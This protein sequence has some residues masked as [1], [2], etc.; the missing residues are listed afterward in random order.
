MIKNYFIIAL[1]N[2]KKYKLFSFLNISGLALGIACVVL[3]YTYISYELS[4]EKC[5]PKYKRI[6][7]AVSDARYDDGSRK[8]AP[9][10]P[11]LGPELKKSLPEVEEICRF[12]V[13]GLTQCSVSKEGVIS[14]K[15]MES[16][17]FYADTTVFKV[18]D[19]K[20]LAG[21]PEQVM[22][23]NTIAIS[24]EMAMRYFNRI[25]VVGENIRIDK[26]DKDFMISGVFQKPQGNTH[27]TIDFMIPFE[28]FRRLLYKVGYQ[29]LYNAPTW[30]GPYNYI[31]FKEGTDLENV[32]KKL[33]VF[34]LRFFE[35]HYETEEAILE[36]RKILF[37]PISDI[38]LKSKREQEVSPN[39][40]ITYV[41]VFS[42]V[43]VLILIIAGVNYVNISTAQ[44][45]RR[46]KEIG[47]R[48]V[49]GANRAQIIRQYLGESLIVSFIS[50]IFAVLFVDLFYP[51]Y[52]LITG[53]DY[54]LTDFFKTENIILIIIIFVVNGLLAGI[55]PAILA[56]RFSI[57]DNIKGFKKVGSVSNTIRKSLIVMQFFI[58][59]FLIFSTMV[60][61][62]QIRLFNNIDLGFDKE[63][64]IVFKNGN[65]LSRAKQNN[66][67]AIK[68][69]FLSHPQLISMTSSS[70][71]PGS[72]TSVEGFTVEGV[73]LDVNPTYRVVRVDEDY[74]ETLNIELLEGEGFSKK[75]DT[76]LQFIL[77]ENAKIACGAENPVGMNAVNMWGKRGKIVGV[78]KNFNFASLHEGIEALILQYIPGDEN[79][80]TFIKFS[81]DVQ[82]AIAAIE[83][84]VAEIA[85]DDVFDYTFIET[86]WNDLYITEQKAA[87]TFKAFTLLAIII[88]C[89]G[90]FGLASFAAQ[91]RIKEM[92]IRKVHGAGFVNIMKIFALDFLRLILISSIISL[93][94]AWYAMSEWLQGFQYR[95]SIGWVYFAITLLIVF[96]ISLITIIYQMV[97]V[98]TANPIDYIK[99][100]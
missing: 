54:S 87:D 49:I 80:S 91:I 92:G 79:G 62:K 41:Y 56:S 89:I 46:V 30:A 60:V 67:D 13:F 1:R 34:L 51:Y 38:H 98:S 57:E 71:I 4:Y 50:A 25:D 40:D 26:Q 21:S 58:S 42:I 86:A 99:Y 9:T 2:F 78:A 24:D 47:L 100:E 61:Y 96:I 10:S 27:L 97:K 5:Y 32:Y 93:P 73:N 14:K 53:L 7:R 28:Y 69:E 77:N 15:F 36:N 18:F 37:Q 74:L 43:A 19:L 83:K 52:N 17:G 16:N 11:R 12:M 76:T 8:W 81:G 33:D 20:L 95:I 29:S 48:K 94:V 65:G 68:A 23:S 90:L 64:I 6:Y 66:C 82:T 88:S 39:S 3:I 72:R 70:N 85:P 45:M 63:N 75:S 84:K 55:Y 44:S 31:L 22:Q 59:V 35:G